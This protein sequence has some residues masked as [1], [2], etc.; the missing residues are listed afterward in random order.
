MRFRID[1]DSHYVDPLTFQHVDKKY[2]HLVPK[3][4]F[5][6]SGGL[7]DVKFDQDPCPFS[8]NPLPIAAHNKHAGISN[9]EKRIEDF[10]KLKINYQILNPQEHTLR[11]SQQSESGLAKEISLSYNRTL[12]AT[13]K[14]YP[15]YFA[16]PIMVPLQ[17]IE[18]SIK[19]LYWAKA[20][21]INS[22]IIDLYWLYP[23]FPIALPVTETPGFEEFCKVCE[24][25]DITISLH[26][27][28]HHIGFTHR[29]TFRKLKLQNFFPKNIT[30]VLMSFVTSGLLDKFPKLKLVFNEGGMDFI[31]AGYRN[32]A[33][34]GINP[35]RYF[36][37]NF[38]FTIETE[39]KIDLLSAVKLL[40]AER[41]I[42]ATDY[43]HDDEGGK[44]KFS[45]ADLLENLPLSENEK[46]LISWVNAKAVF[47]LN[48]VQPR[49][50]DK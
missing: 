39:E 43:P 41:F 33:S 22:V 23:N 42:F 26:F 25:L 46:D 8:F 27:S 31:H 2:Q 5:D 47:S 50:L 9:I 18:F 35:G 28:M 3:F 14:K 13:I 10:Q 34:L 44:M 21:N 15:E 40:G 7:V 20:N 12:L 30:L 4:E 19:E 11:F 49:R 36:K 38:W 32:L 24:A 17:D 16:G 37:E 6:V 45:D 48:N 1:A 29:P